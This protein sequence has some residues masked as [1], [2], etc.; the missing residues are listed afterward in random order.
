MSQPKGSS[1]VVPA[2][3][4][5]QEAGP[6]RRTDNLR[7]TSTLSILKSGSISKSEAENASKRFA[8]KHFRILFA[9]QAG[10]MF[11]TI[12]VSSYLYNY[13][14]SDSGWSGVTSVSGFCCLPV[15]FLIAWN[16]FDWAIFRRLWQELSTFLPVLFAGLNWLVDVLT[17]TDDF[18]PFLD[19]L[20]FI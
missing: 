3:I 6:P 5:D 20:C 9:Q 17:P 18:S 11:A 1:K 16:N 15:Y 13:N 2:E 14:L 8:G 12:A 10:S 19:L 4:V 7:R